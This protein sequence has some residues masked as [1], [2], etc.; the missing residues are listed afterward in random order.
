MSSQDTIAIVVTINSPRQFLAKLGPIEGTQALKR[1]MRRL[2]R[3]LESYHGKI[4]D[5][6]G[7]SISATLSD[8]ETAIQAARSMC[9][10]IEQLPPVAG[11]RITVSVGVARTAK[12]AQALAEKLPPGTVSASSELESS[13]AAP[14]RLPPDEQEAEEEVQQPQTYPENFD[15]TEVGGTLVLIHKGK[16]V[17]V[18]NLHRE[19]T[20]GRDKSCTL[21]LE[22]KWISRVHA[23]IVKD[24]NCFAL[25]D[26]STNGTFLTAED[27]AE[28]WVHRHVHFLEKRGRI[29]IGQSISKGNV[30]AIQFETRF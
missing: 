28:V 7:W 24:G 14:S 27:K 25:I 15:R 11:M 16:V 18:D 2:Q 9:Q 5:D 26:S 20:I 10:R 13:L 4:G 23:T 1:C 21:Q 12:A 6:S 3:E 30:S 17:K 29:S 22:G 8:A 19:I